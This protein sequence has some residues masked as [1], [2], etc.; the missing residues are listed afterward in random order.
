[1][2]GRDRSKSRR[3]GPWFFSRA[4]GIGCALDWEIYWWKKNSMNGFCSHRKIGQ[5]RDVESRRF[6][7][8]TKTRSTHL[9]HYALP[10]PLTTPSP[11]PSIALHPKDKPITGTMTRQ[12]ITPQRPPGVYSHNGPSFYRASET[13]AHPYTGSLRPGNRTAA[14]RDHV[15]WRVDACLAPA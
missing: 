10:T 5:F 7:S 9:S 12:L 4:V 8:S 1:M 14:R 6:I 13:P 3:F 15:F 11:L 2:A